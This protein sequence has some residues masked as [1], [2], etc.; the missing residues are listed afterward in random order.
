MEEIRLG[1][2]GS[3]TIVH[4][5]LDGVRAT[6]GICL[7][8]VYSRTEQKA[9]TLAKEYGCGRTYTQ[10]D[11]LLADESVNTVYIASPN[12]LHYEQTK[13]ALLAGKFDEQENPDRW[14]YEIQH[15]TPFMLSEDFD[16]ID[17]RLKIT[18]NTVRVIEAARKAVGIVFPLDE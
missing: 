17:E 18:L 3:G 5:V 11:A 6:E 8:A 1:T 14:Y 16:A 13:K 12:T 9:D 15:L 4:S 10:L 2:I 7:A